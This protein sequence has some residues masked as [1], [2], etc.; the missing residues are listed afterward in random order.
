MDYI[1]H[2]KLKYILKKYSIILIPRYDAKLINHIQ[3]CVDPFSKVDMLCICMIHY[4]DKVK[5][6]ILN[7]ICMITRKLQTRVK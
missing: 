1:P 6:K 2:K 3:K 7:F 4:T 5:S